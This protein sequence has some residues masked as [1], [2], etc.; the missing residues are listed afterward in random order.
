MLDNSQ[1][2]Q[3]NVRTVRAGA[4]G[5]VSR[6]KRDE[7]GAK[8]WTVACYCPLMWNLMPTVALSTAARSEGGSAAMAECIV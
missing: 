5:N 8:G 1:A 6:G 2:C 7:S 3:S 4:D